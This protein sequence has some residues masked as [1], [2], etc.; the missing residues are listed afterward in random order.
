MTADFNES[1]I[2]EYAIHT[3]K[4]VSGFFGTFRFL[5]NF[6]PCK[7]HYEG[8]DYPSVENAY[9]AAKYPKNQRAEFTMVS[10]GKS[11][12]MGKVAPGLDVKK[13]DKGKYEIMAWLVFQKFTMHQTLKEMLLA[14]DDAELIEANHWGDEWWGVN[15]N[16]E[17]KNNLGRILMGV[18]ETIR[19]NKL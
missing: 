19:Q 7:I 12:K 5:S 1:S 16:G 8:L 6:W 14:T 4:K 2:P 17:G 18:R 10:A 3:D 9:Q 11:K 13:W 15:E